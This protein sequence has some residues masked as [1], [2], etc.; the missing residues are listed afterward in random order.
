MHPA[1]K[2]CGSSAVRRTRRK[3]TLAHRLR[4]FFG[5]YPWECLTC[6]ARFFSQQRYPK[7]QRSNHGEVYIGEKSKHTPDS[8][9]V[10][11]DQG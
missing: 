1:C 7:G 3:T 2:K 8:K 4:H 9:P 6:Q 5:F 10:K 11:N